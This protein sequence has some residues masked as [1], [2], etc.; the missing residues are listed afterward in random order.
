MADEPLTTQAV[1]VEALLC[2]VDFSHATRETTAR[3][4]DLARRHGLARIY[5]VHVSEIVRREADEADARSLDDW[6]AQEEAAAAELRR[7]AAALADHSGLEVVP[8]FRTGIAWREVVECARA[9]R[10]GLLVV[11]APSAVRASLDTE[12][13][14]VEQL[15][16]AA[17]CTVVAVRGA[18]ADG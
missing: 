1:P 10:V 3:A 16:R 17:P 8:E 7:V 4:V 11:G 5:L 12:T 2:A 18:P 15:M 14:I 6:F 9:L 13:S